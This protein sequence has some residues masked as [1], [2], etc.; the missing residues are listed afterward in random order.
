MST[1]S[2][3]TASS[4][5]SS[6]SSMSSSSRKSFLGRL[7]TKSSSSRPRSPKAPQ[8]PEAVFR[9]IMALNARHGAPD[10]QAY[11]LGPA[12]SP[13]SSSR[14]SSAS[15]TKTIKPDAQP[16]RYSKRAPPTPQEV[17]DEIMGLNARHGSGE[18]QAL[19]Y[20]S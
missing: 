10:V 19:L 5:S 20:K 18:V 7:F 8:D 6:S 15:S 9:E 4:S 14:R 16:P 17:F 2:T 11:A 3:V 1:A 12:P 13:S